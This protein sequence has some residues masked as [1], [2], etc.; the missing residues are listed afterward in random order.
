MGVSASNNA[1]I[2][3]IG[4][5]QNVQFHYIVLV[6]VLFWNALSHYCTHLTLRESY[7]TS[8]I[9]ALLLQQHYFFESSVAVGLGS[10]LDLEEHRYLSAR[11]SERWPTQTTSRIQ[12]RKTAGPAGCIVGQRCRP[13][14][15]YKARARASVP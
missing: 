2:A 4:G 3:M 8:T 9:G 5:S 15:S 13:E 14:S 11:Q 7:D 6:G 1:M 10:C 12:S